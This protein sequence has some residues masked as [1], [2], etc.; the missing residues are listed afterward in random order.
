M[1]ISLLY[2]YFNI[3]ITLGNPRYRRRII[4]T[5]FSFFTLK[6]IA[7]FSKVSRRLYY[8]TGIK[9]AVQNDFRQNNNNE[10]ETIIKIPDENLN[11]TVFFESKYFIIIIL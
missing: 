3:F 10:Y 5:L 2:T 6:E 1:I 7:E 8:I 9:E 11:N 4:Q